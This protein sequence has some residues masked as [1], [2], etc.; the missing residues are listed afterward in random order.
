MNENR[1]EASTLAKIVDM[2]A[3]LTSTVRSTVTMFAPL[4]AGITLAITFLISRI[5]ATI[6]LNGSP[7][8]L[9]GLPVSLQGLSQTFMVENI[10]P[11][12]FVFIIGIYIVELVVLLTRFV[13]GL[14]EGDDNATF[15]YTLGRTLPLS[16]GV[17]SV[18]VSIG[19]MF[20]SCLIP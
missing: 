7:E 2:L 19:L 17:F 13:T 6:H 4:I 8:T 1:I 3:E 18:T 10:H 11:D 20:F 9:T 5:L 15:F 12:S 16:L 14:N